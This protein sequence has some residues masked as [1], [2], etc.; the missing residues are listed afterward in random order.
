[1]FFFLEIDKHVLTNRDVISIPLRQ[2]LDKRRLYFVSDD[3]LTDATNG[4]LIKTMKKQQ[5]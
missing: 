2:E 4:D 5:L 3:R 1:M